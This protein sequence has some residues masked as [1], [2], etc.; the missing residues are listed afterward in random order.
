LLLACCNGR[1]LGEA[2]LMRKADENAVECLKIKL[3]EV[4]VLASDCCLTRHDH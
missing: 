3:T 2:L 4:L 1:H